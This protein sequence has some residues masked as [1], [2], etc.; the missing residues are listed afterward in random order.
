ME[1]INAH[2]WIH[3]DVVNP[4]GQVTNWLVQ[5]VLQESCCGRALQKSPWT[6]EPRLLPWV[7]RRRTGEQ[8]ERQ[9]RQI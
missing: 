2:A 4:D 6:S 3:T 1:W 7:I 9:Q 8:G 5:W